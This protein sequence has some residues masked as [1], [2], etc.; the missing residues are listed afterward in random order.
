[1]KLGC[2]RKCRYDSTHSFR[3]HWI[4][5]AGEV[6]PFTHGAHWIWGFMR[7]GSSGREERIFPLGELNPACSAIMLR[8]M[9]MWECGLDLTCFGW[10]AIVGSCEDGNDF[11]CPIKLAILTCRTAESP[12]HNYAV[13][14]FYFGVSLSVIA[15]RVAAS[16]S[17]VSFSWEA[18][19]PLSSTA[20]R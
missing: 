20:S 12:R 15:P 19:L 6:W 8:E 1:M 11:S 10:N 14:G 2:K 18:D 16:G 3:R 13:Q 7:R 9:Q 17:W 4:W 5:L